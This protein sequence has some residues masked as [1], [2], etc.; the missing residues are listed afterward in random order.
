MQIFKKKKKK[1]GYVTSPR[2]SKQPGERTEVEGEKMGGG[3]IKLGKRK[4]VKS[5]V[6]RSSD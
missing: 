3:A 5:S 6:W 2:G 1:S 4:T